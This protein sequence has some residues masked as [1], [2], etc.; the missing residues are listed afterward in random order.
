[1]SRRVGPSVAVKGGRVGARVGRWAG[2]LGGRR[3]GW[4]GGWVGVVGVEWVGGGLVWDMCGVGLVGAK[5]S[6]HEDE[7]WWCFTGGGSPQRIHD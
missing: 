2:G 1:M 7:Q 4:V 6:A 5:S 3:M